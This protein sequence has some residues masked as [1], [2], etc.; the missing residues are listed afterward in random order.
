MEQADFLTTTQIAD[1]LCVSRNRVREIAVNRGVEPMGQ[2]GTAYI[3]H[4]DTVER[5]KPGPT[6]RPRKEKGT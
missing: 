2:V 5:L 6:G 4:L 1:A 3:W